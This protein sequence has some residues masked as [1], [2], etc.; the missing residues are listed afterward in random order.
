VD[1]VILLDVDNTLLDNDR[2]KSDVAAALVASLGRAGAERFS[3]LYEQARSDRDGVVDYLE[4][5]RRFG[6][7]QPDLANAA[8]A[9]VDGVPFERYLYPGTRGAVEACW[10]AGTPVV[11]SDGDPVYQVAK[12]ERSGIAALV[13]GGV[14]VYDHKERHVAQV[15][16]RF[17]AHRYIMV[18][19]KAATLSR[20]KE[21]MGG[22]L[23]SVHVRQGHYADE[24]APGPPPDRTIPSIDGLA[25]AL[26]LIA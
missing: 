25:A 5:L 4:V 17:P 3:E 12:I 1:A 16:R 18:D 6:I 23:T 22:R 13:R 21:L 7:E 19:D 11:L 26:A 15:M 24:E 2:L 8:A 10:A 9:I 14:L 20:M